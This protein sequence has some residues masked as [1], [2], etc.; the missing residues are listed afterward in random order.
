MKVLLAS[1]RGFCA[2]V[3]MAIECLEECVKAF[4]PNIYVYHEIVHNKYVVDKFSKQ[5]VTFVESL[6]EV[7]AGSILLYSAHG[8]SPEVRAEARGRGLRTIDATCPLVTK[9]H[10]EAVKYA[11]AHYNIILIGHEGHDEVIGTMGEAPESITLVETPEDVDGLP[12][13]P[14]DKLVYLTQTTLSVQEAGE[15]IDRL[16]QKYPNIES[17]PKEDICY[18]TTNRQDAVKQLIQQSDLLLVLGSQNSS[19][20][21]RL[22]EIGLTEGRPAYL[23]DG[24]HELKEE[25]FTGINTVMVTAGASAPE[26]VVEECL[27]YLETTFGATVEEVTTREEHVT[28]PLPKELRKL[29]SS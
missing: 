9:V 8:V 16:K 20:S 25:W 7:P 14:D 29:Q 10:L 1:P 28:F 19:N 21:K 6:S 11:N 27:E 15:V 23:I 24:K 12:F 18:A 17:P 22:M 26:V 3:N 2:G 4:G 5:G 13:S